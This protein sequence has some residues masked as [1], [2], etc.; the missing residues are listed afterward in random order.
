MK[1]IIVLC[2]IVALL[3]TGCGNLNKNVRSST[4]NYQL[5]TLEPNG[6]IY[7]AGVYTLAPYYSPNGKLCHYVNGVIVEID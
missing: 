2:L 7:V 4:D 5:V 6:I 3:L 1:K